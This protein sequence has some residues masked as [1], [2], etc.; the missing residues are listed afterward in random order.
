M[1]FKPNIKEYDEDD[2]A[3]KSYG[4][5]WAGKDT[6]LD[7]PRCLLKGLINDPASGFA[8]TNAHGQIELNVT[9]MAETL[10]K[11]NKLC[12]NI[13][14]ASMCTPGQLP[15]ITEFADYR[16]LNGLIRDRNFFRDG[17][18]IWLVN[19]RTKTETQVGRE[20]FIPT[21]CYPRLSRLLETY[22]LVIR[23]LEKELAY[24]VYGKESLQIY[25]EYMWVQGGK[26]M[27]ARS[28][29][30][31]FRKFLGKYCKVD[32]GIKVYRQ[33]CVE[34]GRVFLGSEY[35]IVEEGL[36]LLSAQRGHSL[37]VEQLQYAPEV[38]HLPAMS[39]DRLLRYG[40]VS[41]AWWGVGGFAESPPLLPLRQRIK[42]V[43]KA[44]DEL[45]EMIKTLRMEIQ[46]LR[47]DL[48]RIE[49][50]QHR[51]NAY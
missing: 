31:E 20:S 16:L 6:F 2:W 10:E 42:T 24:H 45:L 50:Q 18:D 46:E 41:E 13:A 47:D 49:E 44:Q 7:N 19:R 3:D 35:E 37:R 36:D 40:R 33:L 32:V 43:G 8:I 21:K 9:A 4:I 25:S 15:R 17:D 5:G 30:K 1:G 11:C 38:N 22:F 23:P 26:K 12:R 34:I 48:A 27:S 29:Y 14:F 39:S 51:H 28:I